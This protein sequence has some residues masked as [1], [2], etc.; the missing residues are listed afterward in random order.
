MNFP[1]NKG[2]VVDPGTRH[3]MSHLT[4]TATHF[5]GEVKLR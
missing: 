3:G 1:V 2:S 4:Q 5:G